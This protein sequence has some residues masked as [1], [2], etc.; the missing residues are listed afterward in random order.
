MIDVFLRCWKRLLIIRA[1]PI[2][3]KKTR[4]LARINAKK[5]TYLRVVE[6]AT[7]CFRL[8]TSANRSLFEW[9]GC[10]V[11]FVELAPPSECPSTQYNCGTNRAVECIGQF[12]ICWLCDFA[13]ERTRV[14]VYHQVSR[15]P[16]WGPPPGKNT[17]FASAQATWALA[18]ARSPCCV[19]SSQ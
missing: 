10:F 7:S 9:L 13:F 1:A 17:S 12:T 11:C 6:V 5:V 18:L 14:H 4:T 15:H 8:R 16:A 19:Q 2:A 3:L